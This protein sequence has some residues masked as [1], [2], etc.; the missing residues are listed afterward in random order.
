MFRVK[1]NGEVRIHQNSAID[2]AAVQV[3]D[4]YRITGPCRIADGRIHL[5]PRDQI[6][7]LV[8]VVQHDSLE[9]AVRV[10]RQERRAVL[11]ARVLGDEERRA[12][13]RRLRQNR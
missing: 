6:D 3:G 2:L 5:M 12:V 1:M 13:I 4:R 10:Q 7:L 9:R 11:L 8:R